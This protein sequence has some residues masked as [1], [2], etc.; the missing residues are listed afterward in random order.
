M[1]DLL[2]ASNEHV[3]NDGWMQVLQLSVEEKMELMNIFRSLV[4][5][6][7]KTLSFQV[8]LI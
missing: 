5:I 6:F 2:A 7:V 4:I 3:L 1:P 8:C